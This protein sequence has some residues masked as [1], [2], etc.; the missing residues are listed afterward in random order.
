MFFENIEKNFKLI[1]T[2][3][4]QGGS[5]DCKGGKEERIAKT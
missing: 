2:F 1:P 3:L 4:L 5:W